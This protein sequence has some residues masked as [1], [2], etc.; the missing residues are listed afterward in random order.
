MRAIA[1][2]VESGDTLAKLRE[3]GVD[4]AQGFGIGKPGP[5]AEVS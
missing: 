5:I 4:Y 2:F 1:E 3:I